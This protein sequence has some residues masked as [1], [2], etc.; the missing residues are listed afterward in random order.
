MLPNVP[1]EDMIRKLTGIDP[2]LGTDRI[3]ARFHKGR[4]GR[5]TQANDFPLRIRGGVHQGGN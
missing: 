1:I 3:S 5:N 2:L 4:E